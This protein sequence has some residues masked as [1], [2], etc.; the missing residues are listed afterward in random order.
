MKTPSKQF[1]GVFFDCVS[2]PE[3]VIQ[4]IRY[5]EEIEQ[6]TILINTRYFQLRNFNL[7]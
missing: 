2:C 5:K 1:E 7:P 6:K 4:L 3:I